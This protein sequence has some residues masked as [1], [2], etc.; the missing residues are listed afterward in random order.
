M[1]KHNKT[2]NGRKLNTFV[3][4]ENYSLSFTRPA[5]GVK[6]E[7]MHLN[8]TGVNPITGKM[9]KVRLNGRAVAALRRILTA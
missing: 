3:K 4:N 7:L 8:V 2:K 9:N 5:K 1:T 6:D